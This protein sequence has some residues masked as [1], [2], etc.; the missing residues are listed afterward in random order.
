MSWG[1]IKQPARESD[2]VAALE[3][4]WERYRA[5]ANGAAAGAKDEDTRTRIKDTI[6]RQASALAEMVAP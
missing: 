5:R 1:I 2:P 6:A 3:H 4:A